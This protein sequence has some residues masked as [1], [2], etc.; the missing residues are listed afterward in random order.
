MNVNFLN[1]KQ[2]ISLRDEALKLVDCLKALDAKKSSTRVYNALLKAI[3]RE[4]R[5]IRLVIEREH[6][7][8]KQT[9]AL[10]KAENNLIKLVNKSNAGRPKKSDKKI[11]I[12]VKLPPSL[13][14]WMDRQPESRAVLIETGLQGFY[15]IPDY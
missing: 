12:N 3:E 10:D 5:R 2:L 6:V 4:D 8:R 11:P 9:K 1:L 14:E 13:I 7:L 15:Q